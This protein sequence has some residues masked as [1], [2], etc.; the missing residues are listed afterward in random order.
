[1]PG[2]CEIVGRTLTAKRTTYVTLGL[3]LLA[4][5]AL[6]IYYRAKLGWLDDDWEFIFFRTNTPWDEIFTPH[7]SHMVVLPAAIFKLYISVFGLG[8]VLPMHVFSTAMY[9]LSAVVLFFWMRPLVGDGASL[10]GCAMILFLGAAYEDL[11]W[12]FQIGFTIPIAAGLGGLIMLRGETARGDLIGCGLLVVAVLGSDMGLMPVAGAAVA[13]LFRKR[14]R[15]VDAYVVLVPVAVYAGWWLGWGHEVNSAISS[16]NLVGAPEYVWNAYR[17]VVA[18]LTGTFEIEGDAGTW[19]SA[20]LALA[21]AAA[22]AARLIVIRRVPAQFLVGAACAVVFWSLAALN[23]GDFGRYNES[24]YLYPGAV[25]LL[26]AIAGAFEGVILA[27]RRLALLAALVIV[28]IA[29]NVLA[30]RDGYYEVFSNHFDTEMAS[31]TATEVGRPAIPPDTLVTVAFYIMPAEYF[32]AVIDES[33]KAGWS[34]EE[35]PEQ[36]EYART[37]IDKQLIATLPVSIRETTRPRPGRPDARCETVDPSAAPAPLELQGDEFTVTPEGDVQVALGRFATDTPN[38]IGP[39]TAG[40]TAVV[41][42]PAD[43]S[44]TPWRAAFIGEGEVEVC[45]TGEPAG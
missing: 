11:L 10:I 22:I 37:T 26:M 35:I 31:A 39:V 44:P 33:G 1:M 30:L 25:F 21:L 38:V 13:L 27:G 15:L 28:P 5:A 8:E 20:L 18:A 2:R 23:E 32:H 24:R 12:A 17:S 36:S 14:R 42:I 3:L 7:N 16:D 29:V 9:L 40:S 19:I 4:A 6:Q 34:L 43:L 41:R 45:Q